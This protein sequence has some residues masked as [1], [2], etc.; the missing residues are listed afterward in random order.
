MERSQIVADVEGVSGDTMVPFCHH[1][2]D[3]SL[4]ENVIML[5]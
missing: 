1:V 2:S 5:A 3:R 4:F